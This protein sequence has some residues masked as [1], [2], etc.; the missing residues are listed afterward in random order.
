VLRSVATIEEFDYESQTWKQGEEARLLR[1]QHLKEELSILE[2][3]RGEEFLAY[4][5]KKGDPVLSLEEA[6]AKL[7]ALLEEVER[8]S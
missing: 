7:R 6:K 3:P 2:G 5:R 8:C 4:T 1:V